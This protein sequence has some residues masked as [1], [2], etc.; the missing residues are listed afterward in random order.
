MSMIQSRFDVKFCVY[1]VFNPIENVLI[2]M[3]II[4]QDISSGTCFVIAYLLWQATNIVISIIT[5]TKGYPDHAA[6]S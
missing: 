2:T 6:V 1:L 5:V 4:G 3:L